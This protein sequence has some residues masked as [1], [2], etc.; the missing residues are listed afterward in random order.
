M[1]GL[2]FLVFFITLSNFIN[3]P[4]PFFKKLVDVRK[5]ERVPVVISK[6]DLAAAKI[7]WLACVDRFGGFKDLDL[8]YSS[9]VK[10]LE[11][12]VNHEPFAYSNILEGAACLR[13]LIND[14]GKRMPLD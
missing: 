11:E 13:A 7:W 8:N 3:A 1:R 5:P 9:R 12:I 4:L 10:Q 2:L 14:Y 6:E